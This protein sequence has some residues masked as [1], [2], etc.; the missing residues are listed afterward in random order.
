[1][2]RKRVVHESDEDGGV[3][4]VVY[5]IVVAVAEVAFCALQTL[6]FGLI[7]ILIMAAA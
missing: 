5:E 6:L 2:D 3:L 4:S 1:M 7:L